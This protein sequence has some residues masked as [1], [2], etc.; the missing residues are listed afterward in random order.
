MSTKKKQVEN[1]LQQELDAYNAMLP[2]LLA[3]EGKYAVFFKGKFIGTFSSYSDALA[4][5]YGKAKLAPFLAK[6]IS[7][8]ESAVHFIRD[9]VAECLTLPSK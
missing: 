6:R 2:A 4:A 8:N 7:G 9:A 1:P 5:G 3:E